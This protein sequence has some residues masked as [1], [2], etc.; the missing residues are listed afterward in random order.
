MKNEKDYIEKVNPNA[1]R[2]SITGVIEKREIMEGETMPTIAGVAAVF[3]QWTD[4]GWC[5]ERIAPG[6][7]DN[8]D[9]SDVVALNNH[10]EDDILSRTT[11]KEDDLVL[12]ITPT[13][14]KFEF[15]AKNECAKEAADNIGLGFIKGCSY[16]YVT[17]T[18]VWDYQ[19]PQAD[20]T[21]MDERTIT[22]I[23]KVYDVSVVTFPAYN[24]TSVALRSRD[25]NKP[26]QL[27]GAELKEKFKLQ[28]RNENK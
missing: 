13:E 23:E 27:T 15:K 7:L 14:F 16:A 21:L 3:N 17:K 2:R 6:A 25:L 19:V 4:L 8:A 26:K 1:E 5:K 24:Q 18:D 22:A 20:G 12:A 9:L 11:G 28:I 10:D